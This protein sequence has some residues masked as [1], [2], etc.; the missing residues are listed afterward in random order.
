VDVALLLGPLYHLT[1]RRDRLQ[2][3]GEARRVVRPGG[4]IVVAGISRWSPRLYGIL[5]K[6]IYEVYE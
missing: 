2:A 1:D 3:L 6:R 4:P 5:L